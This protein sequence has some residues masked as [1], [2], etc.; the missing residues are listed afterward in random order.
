MSG[1]SVY[2]PTGDLAERW[3][4]TARTYT[5]WDPAGTVTETRP[6]T[7]T[8]NTD[9]DTRA[10]AVTEAGNAAEID[11][12]LDAAIAELQAIIDTDN[13]TINDN[14]AGEIK[15]IARTLKKTIRKLNQRFEDT[16]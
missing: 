6:Y 16:E 2:Y 11:S 8:E 5:A 1:T 4:D 15:D 13:A 10:T 14:P 3:D 9:A 12:D 7:A